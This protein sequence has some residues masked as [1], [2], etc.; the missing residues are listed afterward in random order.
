MVRDHT[1][2]NDQASALVKK[3]NVAPQDNGTSKSLVKQADA[4][5]DRTEAPQR[6]GL[7]QGLCRQRSRLSQDGR[8]RARDGLDPERQQSRIEGSADHWPQDLPGSRDACRARCRVTE[9][10]RA[11][12]CETLR[13]EPLGA[14]AFAAPAFS[15]ETIRIAIDKLR[16]APAQVSALATR[17]NGSTATSSRIPPRPAT[18]TGM[19]RSRRRERV[20]SPRGMP[21]TSTISA[22]FIRI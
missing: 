9:I 14:M 15:A 2:V 13:A 5:Q 17:S 21:A 7:R 4:K 16:F 11:D 10:G 8:R 1:S 19:S 22:A 20:V 3:L 12:G 6:R 18:K